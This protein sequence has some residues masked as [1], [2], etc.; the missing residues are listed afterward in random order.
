MKNLVLTEEQLQFIEGQ[1]SKWFI[2]QI[3]LIGKKFNFDLNT[4]IKDINKAGMN[5]I[6]YGLHENFDVNIKNVGITKTY[7]I[8]FD[9][10]V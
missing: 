10:I 9:G 5:A 4:P 8:Q 7:K 6:L 2:K 3:E 1:N